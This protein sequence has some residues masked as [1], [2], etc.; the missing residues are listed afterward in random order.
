MC[1]VMP[2]ASPAVT[3]VLRIASRSD[4]L[5]W[6]TWPMMV[7]TGGRGK[8]VSGSS[9]SSAT[10]DPIMESS[11]SSSSSSS[12]NS[13]SSSSDAMTLPKPS[14]TASHVGT[15]RVWDIA[16]MTP[17]PVIRYLITPTGVSSM[18][19]ASSPT[20]MGLPG[21]TTVLRSSALSSFSAFSALLSLRFSEPRLWRIAACLPRLPVPMRRETRP[22]PPR[23]SLSPRPRP[24]RPPFGPLRGLPAGRPESAPTS[25]PSP[26][27]NLAGP[28]RPRPRPSDGPSERPRPLPSPRPRPLDSMSPPRPRPPPRPPSGA[29]R[30]SLM[31]FSR[32]RMGPL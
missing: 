12:S 20:V 31:G 22:R 15:S 19:S 16:A 29:R 30:W 1:C 23:P 21:S 18:I 13:S 28:P 27:E 2:P 8:R 17:S 25:P 6:S 32:R 3:R 9:S 10:P 14:T 26:S 4:V 24:P 7:T 11:Q 5:P